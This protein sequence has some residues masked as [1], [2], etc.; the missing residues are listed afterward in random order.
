MNF[1]HFE[2]Q[3]TSE[4]NR[5]TFFSAHGSGPGPSFGFQSQNLMG[6]ANFGSVWSDRTGPASYRT[7]KT[8]EF[9]RWTFFS[10]HGSGPG[11]SFGFQSQNL[12][13]NANFGSVWSDRTGPASYRTGSF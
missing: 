9:N 4:F 8:S 6:N 3:K 11:P 13:G 5:W 1:N 10:A 12:M 2:T 7:E